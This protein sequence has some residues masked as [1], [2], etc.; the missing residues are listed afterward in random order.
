MHYFFF[1]INEGAELE[2]TRHRTSH[3]NEN[4]KSANQSI[5]FSYFMLSPYLAVGCAYLKFP[6]MHGCGRWVSGINARKYM[7]KC[8]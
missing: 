1:H 7:S 8:E 5:I 6:R 3:E 2:G 4:V